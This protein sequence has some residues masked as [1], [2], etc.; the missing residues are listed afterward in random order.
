MSQK[1]K[2]KEKGE[3]ILANNEQSKAPDEGERTE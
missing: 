1:M 3:D 2:V